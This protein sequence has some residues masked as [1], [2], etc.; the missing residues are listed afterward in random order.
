MEPE[1]GHTV[2]TG[3]GNP[4]VGAGDHIP[5]NA[6]DGKDHAHEASIG[7][8]APGDN[9][10]QRYNQAGLEVADHGGAH[11]SSTDDDEELGQVD[12]DRQASALY[13]YR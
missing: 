5:D 2:G 13:R 12:Q 8:A 7:D 3:C 10:P 11:R 1:R 4:W 6:P 9:P